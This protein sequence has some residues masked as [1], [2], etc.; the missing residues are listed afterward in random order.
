VQ[1]AKR[2]CRSRATSAL[3]VEAVTSRW[4]RPTSRTW[5]APP[6][7]AGMTPAS[8]RHGTLQVHGL[9]DDVRLRRRQPT[10]AQ[11]LGDRC[12][13]RCGD[14]SRESDDARTAAL[15]TPGRGGEEVLGR[16]P[17]GGLDRTGCVQLTHHTERERV[18]ARPQRLDLGDDLHQLGTVAGRPQ[19]LG[20]LD[21][22]AAHVRQLDDDVAGPA[23]HTCIQP[24]TT[25]SLRSRIPCC[26][27]RFPAR[28]CRPRHLWRAGIVTLTSPG[29]GSRGSRTQVSHVT[30]QHQPSRR[31][32]G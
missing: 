26:G 21:R 23:R 2:Q 22:P 8:Q 6:R 4:L 24:A 12:Q 1:Y 15:V 31:R 17:A 11:S 14:G 19:R 18:Q 25:D 16:R 29:S 10:V 9:L 28:R 5:P 27:R 20:Q 30:L 3:Q 32:N 7:T 13:R